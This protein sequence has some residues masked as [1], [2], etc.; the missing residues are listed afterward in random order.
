MKNFKQIDLDINEYLDLSSD[1]T[2]LLNDGKIKW[3]EKFKPSQ[4]CLTTIEDKPSDY[5]LGCGSLEKDWAKSKYIENSDGSVY[6]DAPA[7]TDNLSEEDFTIL[8]KQFKGTGFELL[9][10][11]LKERY[12]ISGR[13]KLFKNLPRS[14]MSWHHDINPRIHYAIKTQP[15]C[16]MVIED[17]VFHIPQNQCWFTNTTKNHT[18]FN[19]S[20]EDRIHIVF[21]T[22]S[23]VE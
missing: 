5:D 14:C 22:K 18:A 20:K 7:R 1:L 2:K 15:G 16:Y 13:V 10:E 12:E 11:E 23:K 6:L 4:I 9:Y 19:G 21:E 17:E 3:N 8:C